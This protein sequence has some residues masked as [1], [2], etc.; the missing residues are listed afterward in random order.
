MT[1]WYASLKPALGLD[2]GVSE[3]CVDTFSLDIWERF[4]KRYHSI[5]KVDVA[6]VVVLIEFKI[7]TWENFFKRF[8]IFLHL[9][10]SWFHPFFF[11]RKSYRWYICFMNDKTCYTSCCSKT[12]RGKSTVHPLYQKKQRFFF[13][14]SS[15][16]CFLMQLHQTCPYSSLR[17]FLNLFGRYRFRNTP[18]KP[19]SPQRS[20]EVSWKERKLLTRVSCSL[21]IHKPSR[22]SLACPLSALSWG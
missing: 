1:H 18:L 5:L 16:Y 9:F 11:L 8:Q 6:I 7:L 13:S 17:I 4:G 19:L 14:S 20:V 10:A 21:Q 22:S 15:S 3:K 12:Y 2:L